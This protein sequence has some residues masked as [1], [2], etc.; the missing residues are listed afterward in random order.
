MIGHRSPISSGSISRTSS[1]P[2]VWNTRY[3]AC[4]HSHRSGAAATEMPPVMCIPTSMPD[5]SP[6]SV[7][8]SIV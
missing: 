3:A 1:M 2:I 4:S 6:I 5:S 8:R 7:S